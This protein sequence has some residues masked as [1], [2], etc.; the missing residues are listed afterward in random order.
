MRT[1]IW[2]KFHK[3]MAMYKRADRYSE[4]FDMKSDNSR[5]QNCAHHT[6]G[7]NCELCEPGYDG[8]ATRGTSN[9][10]KSP[11]PE[12]CR[13][14]EAGSRSTS[15]VDGRCE[16]KRNVEGPGCNR[17]RPSTYGLRAENIDGCIECYCSGVTDQCH[18]STLYVQQIPIGI[19]DSHHGFTLTDS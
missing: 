11:R 2:P 4:V 19:Y 17:C 6:A 12:L 5:W 1:E 13:C 15:C 18:E 16:C 9:D 7:E 3:N 8:D 14:N 10:C